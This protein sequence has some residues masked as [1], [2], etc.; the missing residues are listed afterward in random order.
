MTTS[1]NKVDKCLF[2]KYGEVESRCKKCGY[3]IW[4]SKEKSDFEILKDMAVNGYT[5]PVCQKK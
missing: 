1:N 2:V 3:V 5:L 4:V